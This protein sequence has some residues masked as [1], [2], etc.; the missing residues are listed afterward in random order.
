MKKL[1]GTLFI[2]LSPL[3]VSQLFAESK[4]NLFIKAWGNEYSEQEIEF[5]KKLDGDWI[6]F[7]YLDWYKDGTL[8]EKTQEINSDFSMIDFESLSISFIKDVV[9]CSFPYGI[10]TYELSEIK[11]SDSTYRV[12]LL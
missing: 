8:I 11:K 3:L 4:L 7:N 5:I 9:V 6:P 2:L 12:E 10:K 1:I